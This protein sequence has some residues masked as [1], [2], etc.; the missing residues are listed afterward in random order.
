MKSPFFRLRFQ[1][2]LSF[3]PGKL[4]FFKCQFDLDFAVSLL[5][6]DLATHFGCF[7]WKQQE[8]QTSDSVVDIVSI[9]RHH[10]ALG[11]N[12]ENIQLIFFPLKKNLSAESLGKKEVH[13]FYIFH[14]SK[15]Q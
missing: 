5:R 7:N 6:A 11:L 14:L 15:S 13:I 3:L 9:G 2:G 12:Q 1:P 8:V 4:A 10:T